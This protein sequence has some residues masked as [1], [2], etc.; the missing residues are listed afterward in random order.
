ME[1]P[2]GN[3]DDVSASIAHDGLRNFQHS[4]EAS[5]MIFRY[6]HHLANGLLSSTSIAATNGRDDVMNACYGGHAR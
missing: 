2:A 6:Q 4:P 1:Q 3:E 5:T